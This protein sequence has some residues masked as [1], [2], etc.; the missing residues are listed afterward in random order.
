MAINLGTAVAYLNLDTTAFNSGLNAAQSALQQFSRD[1]SMGNLMSGIGS[2]MSNFGSSLTRNVTLPL[3]N[4]GQSA[5]DNFRS[6]ESAFTGV[7]KT[8]DEEEAAQAGGWDVLSDAIKQ[9]SFETA[10]SAEEIAAVME[11][12]GQLGIPLGEAGQDITKF[13]KTM[14]ELG[15]TT[16]ISAEEAALNLAKFMNITGTAASDSDRL[17]AAIVD[18]GN[19]FATQEDQIVNM[20]TRLASAGTMAGLTSQEILALATS[21]SSVGIRAE[22]GGSAMATTLTQIERIV[23]G[24]VKNS[25]DKLQSLAKV[26]GMTAEQFATSWEEDPI[27]ALQSFLLGLGDLEEEGGSAVVILDELGMSGVRQTNM[28][29]AL[30][31]SGENLTSAIDMSNK[32]WDENVALSNEAELRYGTLDSKISQLNERWKDMQRDIAELLIPVLERLMDV[33]Q[34]VIERWKSLTDEQRSFIVR[35]AEVA[36][37]V[38]P[39]LLIFGRLFSV[40]GSVMNI[41]TSLSGILGGFSP[42]ILAVVAGIALL[43]AGF[44]Q[45]WNESE[46]FRNAVVELGNQAKR[47]IQMIIDIVKALWE[48]AK[49]VFDVLI[50][51]ISNLLQHLLPPLVDII[52]AVFNV[53]EALMPYIKSLAELIGTVLT[54]ALKI[55]QPI[56]EIIIGLLS[57]II[58]SIALIIEGIAKVVKWVVEKITPIVDFIKWVVEQIVGFF[59]WLW[60]VLFGHSIIPDICNAFTKWFSETFDKVIQFVKDFVNGVVQ[61]FQ[62]LFGKISDWFTNLFNSVSEWLSN[63]WNSITTW[64]SNLWNGIVELLSNIW[65]GIV[66][67]FTNL[68]S[69]IAEWLSGLWD[70]VTTWFGNLVSGVVEWLGN[71]WDNVTTWLGNVINNLTTW[72]SNLGSKFLGWGKDI[73]SRFWEGLKSIWSSISSWFQ[74]KFDWIGG[75]VGRI[76]DA[77]GSVFGATTKISGSHAS[78]LDYVPYDG[79]IAQLHKGERVLTKSENKDYN[80][81]NTSSGDTY[82]FNNVKD[83]PY[84]YAR[85]IK[86]TKRELEFA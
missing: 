53:I 65:N 76:K 24:T 34:R 72:F 35:I 15:D 44:M 6:F 60:D 54:G 17:G 48:A 13:T 67:W 38:G 20:S 85:Q 46:T 27:T 74:E 1:A 84:E 71:V 78:G 43:V 14:V 45:A 73:L 49:P 51:I 23:Q 56:I 77:V 8:I 55:L 33:A 37:A 79:Y 28:L 64:L 40:I 81:G 19:H 59:E 26:S 69:G 47:A 68:I 41:F 63:L 30:A 16:N 9:M 36:A 70:S 66:E 42:I 7:M 10:S 75:V 31:L 18:L 83:D 39:L 22:A 3:A 50:D 32:A 52:K 62:D 5:I 4:L 57:I 82:I 11:M 80:N 2:T 21:M 25:E 29:K 12:A 86:R 58:E 61:W